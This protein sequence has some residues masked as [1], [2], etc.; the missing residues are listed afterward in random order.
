MNAGYVTSATTARQCFESI[1]LVTAMASG[2]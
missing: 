2:P 1:G